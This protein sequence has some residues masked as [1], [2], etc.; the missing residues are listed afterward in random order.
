MQ[1]KNSKIIGEEIITR[2]G[3]HIL[4]EE[5]IITPNDEAIHYAKEEQ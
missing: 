5:I 2:A 1:R 3:R 4:G